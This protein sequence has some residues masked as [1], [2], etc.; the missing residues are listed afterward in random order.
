MRINS[1]YSG[2]NVR[3]TNKLTFKYQEL[4]RKFIELF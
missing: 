1:L 3:L 4:T 2:I